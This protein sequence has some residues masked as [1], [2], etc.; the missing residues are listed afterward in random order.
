MSVYDKVKYVE[1]DSLKTIEKTINVPSNKPTA[2]QLPEARYI[3]EMHMAGRDAELPWKAMMLTTVVAEA[4]RMLRLENAPDTFPMIF[5]AV[6][7]GDV[8]MFGVPG[9]PFNGVGRGL[10]EA[11]GWKMVIPCCLTNASEGY[12]PMIDS[13]DEGGYEARSSSFK[14]GVAER[15]ITEGKEI[16]ASL[17]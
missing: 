6:S 4:Q 1:V 16:L 7:F 13:Y 14:A 9:E 15:I 12:F 10:K 8:A 2:E 11:E 17:R 5:S 3:N